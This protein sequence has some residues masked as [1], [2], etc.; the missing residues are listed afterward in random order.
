[1]ANTDNPLPRPFGRDPVPMPPGATGP[2]YWVAGPPPTGDFAETLR[3]LWRRKWVV[4]GSMVMMVAVAAAIG[5]LL[6]ARYTAT[7]QVRVGV[8]EA[9]VANI[10]SV[11]SGGATDTAAVQSEGYILRSRDL[12]ARV[13]DRLALD[14]VP[15]FNPALRP[16][17]FWDEIDPRRL[18]RRAIKALSSDEPA[19]KPPPSDT[20][21]GPEASQQSV[22]RDRVI[23]GV[24]A[25]VDVMPLERSHVVSVSAQSQ[26]SYL[27]ARIA[28]TLSKT[29]IE[30]QLVNKL[31]ATERADK[32]LGDHIRRLREQVEKNERAVEDYRRQ[33]SLYRSRT[34][35]VTTQQLAELNTQLVLAQ[36]TK[37]EAEA[38]LKQASAQMRSAESGDSVPEVLASPLIQALKQQQATVERRVAELSAHYGDKHP[39]MRNAI[40]EGNDIKRKIRTEVRQIIAG[41]RNAAETAN[42]RYQALRQNLEQTKSL[43]G[44]DNEQSITLRALEREAEA[45]SALFQQ[46]LQR[47]M[48]TNVQRDLQQANA[49]IVSQAAVPVSPSFPPMNMLLVVAVVGGLLVGFLLVM[50][51]EQLDETFHTD[52]EIEA[53]TNLPALAVVPKVSRWQLSRDLVLQKPTAPFSEA[54][55]KLDTVL[56]LSDSENPSKIVMVASA[57]PNEGKSGICLSLARM[58]AASGSNVIVIDC[59]WR[60]PQIHAILRR[61]NKLGLGDLLAG[62]GLPDDVVY[63]DNSGAHLIFAGRLRPRHSHL[64]YSD[65]MRY[66][67]QSLTRH[68]D[69]V[70]IDTPPVLVGAEILHLSRL[71]D[72][73]IYVVRWG[74]TPRD[75]ALKGLRQ[76]SSIGAP[77]VGTVLSQVDT[78]RYR[79]YA[80]GSQ[81]YGYRAYATRRAV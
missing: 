79:R 33:H 63:R 58:A 78:K 52:D 13:V 15:E 23:D 70:L 54:M 2:D 65:R 69:L 66:L 6:P 36:A 71:V 60:R 8:P 64:L 9:R 44:E 18:F 24:L 68:Y 25:H 27:A 48:E 49:R 62:R 41:L 21:E 11:V 61:P 12:M 67:L 20:A 4:V 22:E 17:T 1:M 77:V 53:Y 32:W 81:D 29:Y 43:T 51:L 37:A 57:V 80:R 42:A 75:I 76:L 31:E 19:A 56:R 5:A 45:S 34:D 35:T 30:Q 38:R 46:F 3:K 72:K 28:N 73:A 16:V 26:D 55:R 74:H 50:V 47:S 59:D 39:Q 40:A 10:E 14:K 7:A